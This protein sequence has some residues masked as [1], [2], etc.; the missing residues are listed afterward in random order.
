MFETRSWGLEAIVEM[1]PRAKSQAP[2]ERHDQK[3]SLVDFAAPRRP[4][5]PPDATMGRRTH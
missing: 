4:A 1:L 3:S 2:A 5:D